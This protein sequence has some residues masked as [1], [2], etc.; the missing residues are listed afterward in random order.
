MREPDPEAEDC[1]GTGQV[2]YCTLFLVLSLYILTTNCR[3]ISIPPGVLFFFVSTCN[4]TVW[5][6]LMPSFRGPTV[7]E[8]H[9]G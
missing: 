5:A 2:V 4:I 3:W 1:A 8:G 7:K 9:A 6:C